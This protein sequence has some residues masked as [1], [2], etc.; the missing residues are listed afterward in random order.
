MAAKSAASALPGQ[1]Q[2]HIKV[3]GAGE[4]ARQRRF[5]KPRG[6]ARTEEAR[7]IPPPAAAARA[8]PQAR[9]PHVADIVVRTM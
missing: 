5:I 9:R 7:L 4:A 6:H 1:R 2:K 8:S 3:I